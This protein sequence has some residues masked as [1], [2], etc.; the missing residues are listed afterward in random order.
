MISNRRRIAN[1]YKARTRRIINIQGDL[2]THP[3][4]TSH[5]FHELNHLFH[6]LI[7]DSDRFFRDYADQIIESGVLPHA[8]SRIRTTR[9]MQT[10]ADDIRNM[11]NER[12]ER[13]RLYR[14][15]QRRRR[16][17]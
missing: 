12:N 5:E 7:D 6:D 11:M 17:R 8:W 10:R 13:Q 3:Q 14:M 4:R 2:V 1:E 15:R 16:N 9:E